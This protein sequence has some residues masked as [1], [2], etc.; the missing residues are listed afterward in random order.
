MARRRI[1]PERQTLYYVGMGISLLGLLSFG[2]TFLSA[3]LNF[4]NFDNFEARGRSMAL[5]AFG[6]MAMMVLG[7]VLS[8]IGTKGVAGS[9][10]VLDPKRSREDLEPWS[11]LTGGMVSDALDEAGIQLGND[12]DADLRFDEKLR[13]LHELYTDG[14]LTREE[15]EREKHELLESN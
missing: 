13:R 7:G 2:S 11:R 14:I 10:L 5:R 3:A 9:G 8:N 4:G 12:P 15:Y 6:G 1:S